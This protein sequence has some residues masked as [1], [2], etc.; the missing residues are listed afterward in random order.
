MTV[1]GGH[2]FT[3]CNVVTV[4]GGHTVTEYSV[5][6]TSLHLPD[7]P[8]VAETL[9]PWR[10]DADVDKVRVGCDQL[11]LHVAISRHCRIRFT[12]INHIA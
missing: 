4:V 3:E 9:L 7:V 12:L 2:T 8:T 5:R 6:P 10:R 1:V 11:L